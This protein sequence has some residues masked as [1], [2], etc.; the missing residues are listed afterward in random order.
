MGNT[1]TSTNKIIF[2]GDSLTAGYNISPSKRYTSV[3]SNYAREEKLNWK[4][5]N[6]GKNGDSIGRCLSRIT[7]DIKKYS[8]HLIFLV[9]G[10]NDFY[11]ERWNDIATVK[12][13]LLQIINT[14]SSKGIEVILVGILPPIPEHIL[15]SIKIIPEISKRL[16]FFFMYEEIAE[17][18]NITFIRSI[19]EGFPLQNEATLVCFLRVIS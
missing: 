13:E 14:I 15:S 4:I 19:F 10:G 7:S 9:L 12:A 6:S 3:I 2:I 5:I 8:P 18:K 11:E 17:E 1:N 16:D